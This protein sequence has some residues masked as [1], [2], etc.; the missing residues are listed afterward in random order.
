MNQPT[1]PLST[2]Q[3][4][5]PSVNNQGYRTTPVATSG[6]PPGI[7]Y[8]VANEAAER[9]SFYGMR[10]IL[11]VFMTQH[12]LGFD[13]QLDPMSEQDAKFWFHIFVMVAYFTPLLGAILADCFWGKYRT[14]IWLS[15]LYCLG[16][17]ALAV[18]E[19]RAGLLVGLS[20]IAVG[21]GAIKPC[22]SSHV[23]DQFGS[24]NQHLLER[25]FGWFYLSINLG[26]F[27]STL[28]TPVLLHWYGPRIAFGVPGVL[29]AVATLAFWM[30]RSHFAHVPA[31]GKVA[32]AEV[33]QG[34]GK[35]VVIR[36]LPVYLLVAVFWSLFDQTGSAW[37]LQAGKMDNVIAGMTILPSQI[38]AANPLLILMLVPLFSYLIYPW[39]NRIAPMTP[40]RRM[41]IGMFLTVGAFSI[42]A[43]IEQN[44]QSGGRPSIGW[45]MLAYLVLTA[46]EV[47]ISITC[48]E[49]S[50]TQAPNSIKSFIMSF[51]M[52]SVALGN[53][54]TAM[55]NKVI[56][57]P[58][59][60]SKLPGA[61][62]YW[63]FTGAMAVAA[64]LFVVVAITYRGRT[65][66][67]D[68]LNGSEPA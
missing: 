50:Y 51:Y 15:I 23:G 10:T 44:I 54:F 26:A 3:N 45:Q 56:Q 4:A 47:M 6:M 62:Y 39:L 41:S 5:P 36:L 46:A 17:L 31:R 40:L 11:I 13:G 42:S 37:V 2:P 30:G 66:S 43:L 24:Q 59:G 58:D 25:V 27:I 53:L 7:P 65:Y 28:L 8:I 18:D 33:F 14:I 35:R 1:N 68:M 64:V 63:F 48:L 52:L 32:L 60:S 21:T 12:L 38:Q 20:L 22:V 55:V 57:N 61:S 19:T 29:M 67:Q 16:H 49:F 34:E 9:F